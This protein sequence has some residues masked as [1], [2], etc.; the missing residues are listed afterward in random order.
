MIILLTVIHE[1]DLIQSPINF[2]VK[3]SLNYFF[4]ETTEIQS[5]PEFVAV[6]LVDEVQIGDCNS[7]GRGPELKAHWIKN[8]LKDDP[9]HLEWYIF[10][11]LDNHQFF[12]GHIERIKR[13]FNQTEGMDLF[14]LTADDC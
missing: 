13:R 7:S 4:T 2:T 11:C 14:H 1:N 12:K 8:L 3:H 5:I 6:A 9:Q 10:Q